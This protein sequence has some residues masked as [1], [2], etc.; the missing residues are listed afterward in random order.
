M[1]ALNI[2]GLILGLAFITLGVFAARFE[3]APGPKWIR[4]YESSYMPVAKW[5]SAA[6][7]VLAGMAFVYFSLRTIF[8]E[9]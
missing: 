4:R 8:A 6:L 1:N 2:F 9:R 7:F 3:V 5:F